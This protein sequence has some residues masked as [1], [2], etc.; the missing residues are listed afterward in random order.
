MISLFDLAVVFAD[1]Y[2]VRVVNKSS[3]EASNRSLRNISTQFIRPVYK[4]RQHSESGSGDDDN[5]ESDT[6]SE[7]ESASASEQ[8]NHDT[9][10]D[11]NTSNSDDDNPTT[12]KHP[13]SSGPKRDRRRKKIDLDT[14]GD[15]TFIP[16]AESFSQSMDRMSNKYD[17]L[18][19][20][21]I[22]GLK[23]IARAGVYTEHLDI[24]AERLEMGAMAGGMRSQ[25]FEWERE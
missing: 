9:E 18:L 4:K 19:G 15:T 22:A 17:Q 20:F 14:D 24:L 2:T 23:S 11:D 5:S 1:D 6:N 21:V 25:D 13:T 10:D 7:T 16:A 12:N 8:E 3:F